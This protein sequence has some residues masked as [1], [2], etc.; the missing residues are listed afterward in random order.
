[1]LDQNGRAERQVDVPRA[2]TCSFTVHQEHVLRVELR[3]LKIL[4]GEEDQHDGGRVC[5]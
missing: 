1:M 3:I 5:R 4:E 2:S